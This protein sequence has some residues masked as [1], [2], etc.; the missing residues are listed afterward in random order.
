MARP[1]SENKI[2]RTSGCCLRERGT[3]AT[4]ILN[5][6]RFPGVRRAT[7]RAGIDRTVATLSLPL[8]TTLAIRS[9]TMKYDRLVQ[10]GGGTKPPV[11]CFGLS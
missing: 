3:K 10:Q 9:R 11:F 1:G 2:R 5:Q 7:L 6:D 4:A 8:H